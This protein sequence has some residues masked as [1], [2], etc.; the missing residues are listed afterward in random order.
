MGTRAD[1]K[2][3]NPNHSSRLISGLGGVCDPP[4]NDTLHSSL[5]RAAHVFPTPR[6]TNGP[7]HIAAVCRLAWLYNMAVMKPRRKDGNQVDCPYGSEVGGKGRDA[8]GQRSPGWCARCRPQTA[9]D[10]R[11]GGA[12][13]RTALERGSCHVWRTCASGQVTRS[14]MLLV[15]CCSTCA[16]LLLLN[17]FV[18]SRSRHTCTHSPLVGAAANSRR[19]TRCWRRGRRCR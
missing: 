13:L 12:L 9:G 16:S 6:F 10:C 5:H 18:S 1:R 17:D 11:V 14:P 7:H 8:D 3:A 19:W 2:F 15:S 4:L